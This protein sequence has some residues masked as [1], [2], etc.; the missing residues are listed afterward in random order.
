MTLGSS[1]AGGHPGCPQVKHRRDLTVILVVMQVVSQKY[2]T[3]LN[4]QG[5][6]NT[7]VQ[8]WYPQFCSSWPNCEGFYF[9]LHIHIYKKMYL[10][11]NLQFPLLWKTYAMAS[12]WVKRFLQE[13]QWASERTCWSLI[14]KWLYLELTQYSFSSPAVNS[15]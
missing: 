14:S 9:P 4:S 15:K 5:P 2:S 10:Q 3:S 1:S 8:V 7:C 13:E 12:A 6:S 11:L